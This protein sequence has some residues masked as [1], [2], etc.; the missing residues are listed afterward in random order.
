MPI[1]G[2][3][4]QRTTLTAR[5]LGALMRFSPGLAGSTTSQLLARQRRHRRRATRLGRHTHL[6]T[7]GTPSGSL[8]LRVRTP[9]AAGPHPI[10][11]HMHG[12][13]WVQG[14]PR[15]GDWMC[16]TIMALTGAVVVSAE[17][18]L[19]PAT[20]HPGPLDD[21]LAALEWVS[22]HAAEL[23]GNPARIAVLGESAGGNLAAA[24]CLR[25]RDAGGPPIVHQTLL[26][27][28]LDATMSSD[29]YRTQS[30]APILPT[31]AMQAAW[32][33]HL[34]AGADRRDPLISPLHAPDLSGLPPATVV[35]AGNDP[36]HD[37]GVEYAQ[38]L[39]AAGVPV[40]FHDFPRMV[41]GF[42][43][44]PRLFSDTTEAMAK[45]AA[46]QRRAFG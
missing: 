43:N 46:A 7:I 1:T 28:A 17:Y 37:E 33:H 42:M 19:G 38:R 31:A 23:D 35:V 8:V 6:R 12:G 39:D 34:P 18:R 26:Y 10:V 32:R 21:C 29:S 45:V 13:G 27:P 41:H 14:S 40:D 36:L 9:P 3:R 4:P 16:A 24:L 11:L 30:T 20:V 22:E 15:D 44:V 25:A 2:E 5:F